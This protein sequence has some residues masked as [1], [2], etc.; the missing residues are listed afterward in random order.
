MNLYSNQLAR[1]K[2]REGR[3]SELSESHDE[4]GH[5]R[6]RAIESHDMNGHIRTKANGENAFGLLA[7]HPRLVGE[8]DI[9]SLGKRTQALTDMHSDL[10]SVAPFVLNITL[11]YITLH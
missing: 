9:N 8:R 6:T 11:H 7:W 1:V 10:L 4:N 3:W 5:I 2:H